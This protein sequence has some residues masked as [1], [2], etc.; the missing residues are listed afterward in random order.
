M[1]RPNLA[2][3]LLCVSL[4]LVLVILWAGLASA[5]ERNWTGADG[6]NMRGT[7]VR[8]EGDQV[9][10][11]TQGKFVTLPISKFAPADQQI[12]RDLAEGKEAPPQNDS[13]SPGTA[14]GSAQEFDPFG[15]PK[16]ASPSDSPPKAGGGS[17]PTGGK[18]TPGEAV[19]RDWTDVQGNTVNGKFLRIVG[20]DVVLQRASRVSKVSFVLL[21]VDDREYVR[22]LLAARGDT[23]SLDS[24]PT[25]EMIANLG[26]PKDPLAQPG[27]ALVPGDPRTMPAQPLPDVAPAFVPNTPG[28]EPSPGDFGAARPEAAPAASPEASGFAPPPFSQPDFGPP[29]YSPPEN[30]PSPASTYPSS[31][32]LN[33][34]TGMPSYTPSSPPSFPQPSSPQPSYPQPSV[35]SYSPPVPTYTP[36]GYSPPSLPAAQNYPSTDYPGSP[37]KSV[38]TQSMP[39]GL[40]SIPNPVG[41]LPSVLAPPATRFSTSPP[42]R[43]PDPPKTV[44]AQVIYDGRT[45]ARQGLCS[46]CRGGLDL[47]QKGSDLYYEG[48]RCPHC[49]E[50]F[51]DDH[52]IR[53]VQRYGKYFPGEKTFGFLAVALIGSGILGMIYYGIRSVLFPSRGR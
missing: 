40:A 19:A 29:P 32:P 12:I 27:G 7:F 45:S 37:Y 41:S 51:W 35:P 17:R 22:Q 49:H 46:A 53:F 13:S 36:P 1:K 44:Y 50:L 6:R 21:S 52:E 47:K 14:S 16:S 11:L 8:Q 33:P 42:T 3:R 20:S 39:S 26:K 28:F 5:Q 30:N 23:I 38:P 25:E 18:S 43:Q 34:A 4:H 10:F 9:T 15:P 24:L 31:P 2:N 48:S